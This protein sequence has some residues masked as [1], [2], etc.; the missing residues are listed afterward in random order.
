MSS[1]LRTWTIGAFLVLAGWA[2][3]AFAA[4]D[5]HMA[6]I[7]AQIAANA[8]KSGVYVLDT[9]TE[10]LLGERGWPTTPRNR[11]KSS[12]SSGALTT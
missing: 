6:F 1:Q 8:G 11:S 9:G 2:P 7:D 3:I 10:A 4:D 5:A 12:I